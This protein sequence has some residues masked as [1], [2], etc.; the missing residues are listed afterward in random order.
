MSEY[1]YYEFLAIDRPLTQQEM[2]SL[3]ALSSR[4][5]IT[6][7]SFSNEYNWGDLRGNPREWMKRFFDLH[8]YVANWGSA[9]FMIR[10]PLNVFDAKVFHSF[11]VDDTFEVEP[12]PTHRVLMWSARDSENYDRFVHE[13]GESWMARLAPLREELLRGDLR[14]L[15]IGWLAA[16]TLT[17]VEEEE[18]EPMALDGLGNFTAAQKA[19]AEFLEVDIDLL[20]GVGL[21]GREHPTQDP[22]PQEVDGWLAGLPSGEVQELLRQLLS[23]QGT[24][25]ERVLKTRFLAWRRSLKELPEAPRRS[26][27]I[28]WKEAEKAKELRLRRKIEERKQEEIK[29]RKEREEYL[30]TLAKNFPWSWKTVQKCVERGSGLGYNEAC[31]HLVDLSEAYSLHSSPAAFQEEFQRFMTEHRRRRTLVERLVNVGLWK[32][33]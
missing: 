16:V 4:A 22:S 19:L 6:P 17:L 21:A 14:S 8:V 23:G 30:S 33:V 28:L 11:T 13:D 7:V 20:E 27:K 24:Q 25:A 10:L 31:G 29:K 1:Q 9:V 5:H 3:R 15:Y 12:S 18:L 26:V 2:D 32:V